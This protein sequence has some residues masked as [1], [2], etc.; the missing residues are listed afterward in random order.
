MEI[1]SMK[2]IQLIKILMDVRMAIIKVVINVENVFLDVHHVLICMY[3]KH[4]K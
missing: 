2:S 4:A 1:V 3:V